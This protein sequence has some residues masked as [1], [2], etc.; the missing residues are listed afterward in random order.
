MSSNRR[1]YTLLYRQDIDIGQDT[2]EHNAPDPLEPGQVLHLDD[3]FYYLIWK[4]DPASP[5]QPAALHL[6]Q[7]AQSEAEAR[8]RSP[9]D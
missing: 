2:Y 6:L 4:I 7:S 8:L 3:G 9:P 1:V 5:G